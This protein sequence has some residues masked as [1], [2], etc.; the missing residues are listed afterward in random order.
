[1][2]MSSNSSPND[3]G[4]PTEKHHISLSTYPKVSMNKQG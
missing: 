1:M 3:V 2:Q 4:E